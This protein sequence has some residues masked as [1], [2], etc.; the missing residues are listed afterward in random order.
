MLVLVAIVGGVLIGFLA[1]AAVIDHKG[2]RR[3]RQIRVNYASVRD[4]R[5]LN[6]AR[7]TM[8][9]GPGH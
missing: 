9:D 7:G 3:G 4:G 8:Y 1:I 6:D 5:Q 2:R